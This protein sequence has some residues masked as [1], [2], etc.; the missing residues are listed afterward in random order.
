MRLIPTGE[1]WCGC[2]KETGIGSFFL[3]GHDK[4]AEAA[5]IRIKYGGVPEFLKEHG[6]GPGERNARRELEAL[7]ASGRR[8]R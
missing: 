3:P 2:E 8:S 5:V 6:F 7:N 4:L 1:C